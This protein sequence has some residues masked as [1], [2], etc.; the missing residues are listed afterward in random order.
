MAGHSQ[1]ANIKH[2][3]GAQDAK[4]A[5]VF[6]RLR[7]EI[8]VAAKSG[9]PDPGFNSRL[10]YA[11]SAAKKENLPKDKIES[12]IEEAISGSSGV[13]Y[14]EVRYEG[15]GPFGTAFIILALT[16]NRNRTASEVRAAFSKAGCSLGE[17]GSVSFMFRHVG[18]IIYPGSIG[19][20]K[21]FNA[22]IEAGAIDITEEESGDYSVIS[23]VSDFSLIR[24]SLEELF[25]ESISSGLKWIP[26]DIVVINDFEKCEKVST[27]LEALEQIDDVQTVEGNFR[28]I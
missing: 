15:Y 17:T 10:R 6:S 25:G 24:D 13:N 18:A 2:R 12:A 16:D 27:F 5:R 19:Y 23:N 28:L 1:F 11:I 21:L 20:E 22:G 26:I 9:L 7:R 8:L 3:K 14:E 4:K